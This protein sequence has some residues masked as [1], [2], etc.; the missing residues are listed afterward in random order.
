[1]KLKIT[2]ELDEEETEQILTFVRGLLG[3]IIPQVTTK[4]ETENVASCDN[5]EVIDD[6]AHDCLDCVEF[7]T[8][9]DGDIEFTT[10]RCEI[11]GSDVT[12]EYEECYAPDEDSEYDAWRDFQAEEGGI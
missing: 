8:V 10:I 2:L 11:C 7:V 4:V 12:E 3:G 1:M 6:D 5:C 9:N